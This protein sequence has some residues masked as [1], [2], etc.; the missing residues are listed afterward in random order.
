M[1]DVF[2]N[3]W[4]NR[5]DE[6]GLPP[7][8]LF[9][10]NTID[11]AGEVSKQI[12]KNKEVL[13]VTDKFLLSTGFIDQLSSSLEKNNLNFKIYASD[14]AEPT[15]EQVNSVIKEASEKDYGL[16]IGIGGGS[17]LDRAKIAACFG[18]FEDRAEDYFAPSTKILTHSKPK[19][20]IPTTAGTGSEVSNTAVVIIPENY[21][22]SAKTW[23][24][25]K[26]ILADA[27]I[28]DPSLMIN[29]PQRVTANTGIDA[30]SHCA[31]GVIS[32]QANPF[33][34]GLAI[35]GIKLVAENIR[36]A[37]HQGENLEARWNM[38]MAAMLGGIVISF[39]WIGGPATLGHAAS[40]GIS[41]KYNIPHGAA[42]GVLLP[43]VYW[44]N[45]K[46]SYAERKLSVISEAM[47]VDTCKMSDQKAAESAIWSTFDLLEDL[48]MSTNLKS[49][50]MKEEDIPVIAKYIFERSERMYAMSGYNPRKATLE[51]MEEFFYAAYEGREYLEK[52]LSKKHWR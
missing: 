27:A 48:D 37:Y 38:S 17:S 33:S 8:I 43:Y 35:E 28:L 9:G 18:G 6:Y 42:C 51:N 10:F 2:L 46:S 3:Y 31:E 36:M 7:R 39:P 16:V 47:G 25:G 11:K 29:L 23:I 30:L 44:F 5:S 40:E 1:K 22:G 26:M 32:K 12:S 19:L 4:L 15:K 49:Y 24:T 50:G 21:V 45:L 14:V 20:L 13:I 41:P 34:D 52:D